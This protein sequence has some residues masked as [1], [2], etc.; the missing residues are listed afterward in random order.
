MLKSLRR[1]F[2]IAG[3]FLGFFACSLGL[4]SESW[5]YPHAFSTSIPAEVLSETSPFAFA[6]NGF[7]AEDFSLVWEGPALEGVTFK[8]GKESF[9]W[10]RTGE[11]FLL[12][13]GR[14]FLEATSLPEKKLEAGHL[15]NLGF[16]QVL[17]RQALTDDHLRGELPIALMGPET[18]SKID[19]ILRRGGQEE[20]GTLAVRFTPRQSFVHDSDLSDF[21]LTDAQCSQSAVK[22]HPDTRLGPHQWAYVGCRYVMA[23]GEA[24]S[25]A[26]LDTFVYWE[27]AKGKVSANGIE[28][29]PSPAG[30][31]SLRLRDQPGDVTL[32]DEAGNRLKLQYFVPSRQRYGSLGFGLGPYSYRYNDSSQSTQTVVPLLTLYGSYFFSEI[33][34]MVAFNATSFT[35]NWFSDT[36]VYFQTDNF[37]VLDKRIQMKLLFGAHVLAFQKNSGPEA[38]FSG[39]QG[40]ELIFK[41][42]IGKGNN[43]S[44]G[45]FIYPLISGRKYYNTW[46]RWG[47]GQLFGEINYID[48]QEPF[49]SS[50]VSSSSIGITVGAP[51]IRF[52]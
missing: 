16:T 34:R 46:V 31:Y 51:L 30:I 40:F 26:G 41:D 5:A 10:V 52:L 20:H 9:E 38:V 1:Q 21:V 33:F 17:I 37:K 25:V 39:P 19:V 12:P 4:Q 45:A 36:G 49:G 35:T 3:L 22:A 24:Y 44:A 18:E 6:P 50:S 48:W 23:W 32:V 7:T 27:G 43:L 42:F 2:Q 28:L 13:R 47:S 14:L 29:K 11:V 8:I 15:R